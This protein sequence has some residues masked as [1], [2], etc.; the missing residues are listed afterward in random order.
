MAAATVEDWVDALQAR[1]KYTFLRAEAISDSGLSAEDV[2][3]A[4][5]RLARRQAVITTT[6]SVVYRNMCRD[7]RNEPWPPATRTTRW[8]RVPTSQ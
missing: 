4:L 5:Q 6:G 2:K 7:S 1:G 3:K 8:K